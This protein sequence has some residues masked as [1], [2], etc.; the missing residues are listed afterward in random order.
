VG[1]RAAVAHLYHVTDLKA[2][3]QPE[4][5]LV[6]GPCIT[7]RRARRRTCSSPCWRISACRCCGAVAG[8]R[9]PHPGH[10]A[11]TLAVQTAGDGQAPAQTAG[12]CCAQKHGGRARAH[13]ISIGL[14]LIRR[15]AAPET[16]ALTHRQ[17]AP[18]RSKPPV[19]ANHMIINAACGACLKIGKLDP[20]T[21]E[22]RAVS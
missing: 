5:E 14:A 13:E 17:R 16:A 4:S 18:R 15:R 8:R 1:R 12:P 9:N 19:R 20:S 21:P 7:S 3:S 6:C 2:C 11:D 22:L 10:P